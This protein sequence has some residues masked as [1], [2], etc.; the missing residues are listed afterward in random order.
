MQRLNAI[1]MIGNPWYRHFFA[2]LGAMLKE[3]SGTRLHVYC[4]S[5]EACELFRSVDRRSAFAAVSV[6]PAPVT[7]RPGWKL[8]QQEVIA[9]ARHFERKYDLT[10]N[11][12]L[13]SDRLFGRGYAPGGYRHPRALQSEESTILDALDIYT[14][15]FEFWEKEFAAHGFDVIMETN[16]SVQAVVARGY[17]AVVRNPTPARHRNLYYWTTDEYGYCDRVEEIYN[18]RRVLSAEKVAGPP[19]QGKMFN[20]EAR[21]SF[22]LR[23]VLGSMWRHTRNH[24]VWRLRGYFKARQYL[25]REQIALAWRRRRDY[26]KVSGPRTGT[27]ADLKGKAFVFYAMHVEPE[28]WFQGRSPEYFYQH[29]AIVSLSRDMPAGVT[30][31]VKEHYPGI[32]RRPDAFYDQ[33]LDLKNVV[34][35]NVNEPGL[36]VV[37]QASAIATITGTVGQEAAVMG[38][39]VVTFGRHN[40]YNVLGHVKVVQREEALRPA[41]AWALDNA[42]CAEEFRRDGERFLASLV[43][44]SFDMKAF[45]ARTVQGYDDQTLEQAYQRLAESFGGQSDGVRA[46]R[47]G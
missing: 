19:H 14:Q 41:L 11:S 4:V 9:R 40:L 20:E 2:D 31:A 3:R 28:L 26:L 22:S 8:D 46:I 5:E 6:M 29:A 13:V 12:L 15:Q 25:W 24:M 30:L 42:H 23:G 47:A 16:N 35:L 39:P 17:G 33:I 32:G 18:S 1:A 27:L 36:R 38:K 7:Y 43:A 37:E 21:Q 44:A 10:Y 45:T 34:L